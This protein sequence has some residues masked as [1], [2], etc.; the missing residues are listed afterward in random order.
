MTGACASAVV[1]DDLD[2]LSYRC[3]ALS[4]L[5]NVRADMEWLECQINSANRRGSRPTYLL[6]FLFLDVNTAP[7]VCPPYPDAVL[8][9]LALDIHRFLAVV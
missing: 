9:L 3:L 7:R 1:A 8:F 4:I 5:M 6:F 2:I